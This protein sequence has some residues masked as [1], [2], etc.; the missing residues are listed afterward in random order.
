MGTLGGKVAFITGAA[1]RQGRSH[2]IRLAREGA[3][4]SGIDPAETERLVRDL[5]GLREVVAHGVEQLGRLDAVIANAGML[6]GKYDE[7]DAEATFRDQIDINL[8]GAWHTVEAALLVQMVEP[9]DVLDAGVS[10]I[11]GAARYGTGITVPVN[12]GFLNR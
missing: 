11:S 6:T 3:D 12:A 10:L 1:H 8:T 9:V 5:D 7:A 4:I 2:A